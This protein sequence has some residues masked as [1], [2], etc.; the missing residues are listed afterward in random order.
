MA[1]RKFHMAAVLAAVLLMQTSTPARAGDV[2][3]G[4]DGCLLLAVA[5]YHGTLEGGRY[6]PEAGG[7]PVDL[8]STEVSACSRSVSYDGWSGHSPRRTRPEERRAHESA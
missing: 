2:S 5:V 1:T 4:F 6:G 8:R 3:L 7:V